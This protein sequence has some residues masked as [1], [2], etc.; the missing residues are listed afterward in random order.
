MPLCLIADD[1][2]MC[3]FIVSAILKK[4]S[5]TVVTVENGRDALEY[6]LLNTPD[7]AILDYN[8][9]DISGNE[10]AEVIANTIPVIIISGEDVQNIDINPNVKAFISKLNKGLETI[11]GAINRILE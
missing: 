7:L 3:L 5:Y 6:C 11:P 8:L 2:P 4:L 10:V 1:D 9:P